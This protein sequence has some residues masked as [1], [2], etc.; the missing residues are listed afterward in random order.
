MKSVVLTMGVSGCGKST[1]LKEFQRNG[2]FGIEGDE[3]HPEANIEKMKSGLP[4]TDDDRW[5]WLRN[6]VEA[7]RASSSQ[8]CAISCSCLKKIYRDFFRGQLSGCDLR[9]VFLKVSKLDLVSRMQAR[10]HFMPVSLLDSQLF[11]LEEPSEENE[12]DAMTIDAKNQDT[13][14]L[15][16]IVCAK[17]NHALNLKQV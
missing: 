1:L 10:K 14:E 6:I 2:Y 4:L 13:S 8:K 17:L 5:P 9:F 16:G 12:P 3:Y 15:F 7:V 11:T